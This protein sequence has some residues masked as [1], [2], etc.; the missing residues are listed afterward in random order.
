MRILITGGFGFLGSHLVEL[1]LNTTTAHIHV[2]DNLSTSPL[3]LEQLFKEFGDTKDRLTYDICSVAEY[4]QRFGEHPVDRIY[5]LASV[6]GPAGVLKHSGR[7]VQSIV[8]DAYFMME[9]AQRHKAR[10]LDVS[11]SEIYGGGVNGA[12]SEDTPK[13]IPSKVSARLEYAVGKLAAETALMNMCRVDG[14]WACII[15]PFNISGPRQSGKGGFVLPRFIWQAVTGQSLTVFGDG[16]QVRAFTHAVDVAQGL[17]LSMEKGVPG[18]TYNL[19]APA[20]KC[21]IKDLAE[22]VI[23][24]AK[25]SS[26][27]ALV[28][29]KTI[30][31]PMYEE[32]NDK[33]PLADRAINE[34]GWRPIHSRDDI[35]AE[36]VDY[37]SG[38]PEDL[39]QTLG[40]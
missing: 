14:L 35:I 26:S 6:V 24:I 1:L 19:G 12:C 39:A 18:Q 31:G 23:R 15:R 32:A 22:A 5:H 34:L 30:Y 16:S 13:I 29:P 4:Y 27:I 36:T 25:S 20:N 28:D 7:I 10:L 8:S 33:F 17:I 37:F 40:E 9:L 2:V 38:L 21:S 3:P 11:T